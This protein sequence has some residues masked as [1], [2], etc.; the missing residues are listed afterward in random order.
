M[1]VF[2]IAIPASRIDDSRA[3]YEHLL[4]M[5]V[6]DTV[7]SR[8][9]F[10]CG[11]VIVALIDWTVEGRSGLQPT[12]DNIYLATDELDAVFERAEA[13]RRAASC[14]RSNGDRGAS[15]PSIASTP[16]ATSSA[17]STTRPLFLGQGADWA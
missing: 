12:P 2:R 3:F 13:C 15:A 14:R 4:G 8:L 6:D 7:P 5:D 10:H 17:S 9:Y 11:G 1:R 16:T